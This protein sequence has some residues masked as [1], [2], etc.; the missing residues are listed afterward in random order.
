MLMTLKELANSSLMMVVLFKDAITAYY[1]KN[2]T[3]L[4]KFE[5][6]ASE[7][8]TAN[9]YFRDLDSLVLYYSGK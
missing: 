7:L 8:K 9:L 2:I 5:Q 1:F 4:N 3:D 6:I